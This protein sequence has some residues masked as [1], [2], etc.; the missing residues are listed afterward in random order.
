[1]VQSIKFNI[2]PYEPHEIEDKDDVVVW[3]F[4]KDEKTGEAL[5]LYDC[6][7]INRKKAK[8]IFDACWEDRRLLK[9][10]KTD[11]RADA[12]LTYL[13]FEDKKD[14]T[15]RNWRCN[16]YYASSRVFYA[17]WLLSKL[18]TN[19]PVQVYS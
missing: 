10:Y 12:L 11:N 6:R 14:P 5:D 4:N 1:M 17:C 19:I 15:G 16:C 2:K 13:W 7:Q 8:E 18:L 9:T 3:V